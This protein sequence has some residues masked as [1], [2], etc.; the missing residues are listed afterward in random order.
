MS[1]N[2]L[3][4]E[5]KKDNKI[6]RIY[7]D[8]VFNDSPR[9]WSNLSKFVLSHKRYFLPCE[10]DINLNNFESWTELEKQLKKD[11]KAVI[12]YAVRGYDHGGL[13]ISLSNN[14]P[15][16]DIWDSGQ[17]GFIVVLK[18]DIIKE[19]GKYNKANLKKA[20]AVLKSE[21]ETYKN[22]L[23]GNVY[24]FELI[25]L[26]EVT[27]TKTY[28]EEIVINEVIEEFCKDT[29]GGYY[30]DDGIKSI[31][32]ELKFNDAVDVTK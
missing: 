13:S 24:R 29:C 2:Y 20:D 30:G 6:L 27:I 32:E 12:I 9:E 25:E 23:E 21:F 4:K 5:L 8:E 16:N 26:K 31:I 14:Y 3:I 22:Y 18:E 7:Q 11:Y 15:F 19:Y 10:I 1:N 28:K 17:L